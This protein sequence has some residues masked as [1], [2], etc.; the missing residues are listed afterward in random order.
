MIFWLDELK[1]GRSVWKK[2][3]L[4]TLLSE[5]QDISVKKTWKPFKVINKQLE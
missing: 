2:A 4:A 3:N 1:E 5:Q